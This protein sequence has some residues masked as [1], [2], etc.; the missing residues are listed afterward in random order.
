MPGLAN[1]QVQMLSRSRAGL[2][3]LTVFT[4]SFLPL[5]FLS[6]SSDLDLTQ[7]RG[8]GCEQD[9]QG[10]HLSRLNG[11]RLSPKLEQKLDCKFRL[12]PTEP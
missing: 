9:S 12:S 3:E 7:H 6:P 11:H 5:Y 8:L 4:H 10:P 1:W 2:P